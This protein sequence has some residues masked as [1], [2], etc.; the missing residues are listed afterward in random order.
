MS[1]SSI[2]NANGLRG[3][4]I[5]AG[6]TLRIEQLKNYVAAVSTKKEKVKQ[7]AEGKKI[8]QAFTQIVNTKLIQHKIETGET[9]GE[10]AEKYKVSIKQLKKTNGLKSS[11]II[12]GK[13]LMIEI[14]VEGDK[15]NKT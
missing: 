13:T 7:A 5:I 6:K 15:K 11:K 10:I 1:V 9:L 4:K 14:P 8:E 2:R 3:S 12:A